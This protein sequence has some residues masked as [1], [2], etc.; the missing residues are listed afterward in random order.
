MSILTLIY[1]LGLPNWVLIHAWGFSIRGLG[2]PRVITRTLS[3]PIPSILLLSP[4][5]PPFPLH[6][7]RF[8][9]IS[10]L[11][12]NNTSNQ[13]ESFGDKSSAS[14]CSDAKPERHHLRRGPFQ[15]SRPALARRCTLLEGRTWVRTTDPKEL[16]KCRNWRARNPDYSMSYLLASGTTMTATGQRQAPH[17]RNS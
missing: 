4:S 14:P 12:A 13:L 10:D 16:H 6:P 17:P 5:L 2:F 15:S 11:Q 7:H 8:P 3:I 9:K 1:A